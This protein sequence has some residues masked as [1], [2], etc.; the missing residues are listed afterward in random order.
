ML[1]STRQTQTPT[2]DGGVQ[3]NS[4]LDQVKQ[5]IDG[6]NNRW[7]EIS[8]VSDVIRQIARNTNLVALNA[9]IEA[10]RAGELGRG[11]AVV[12]DEVRRLATQS[13]NATADIGNVVA[14]IRQESEKALSEVQRAESQSREETAEVLLVREAQQLQSQF[15]M[16]ATAL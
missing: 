6:L 16:M 11:F 2:P 14:T 5:L 3:G 12:A 1:S 10:A 4:T 15:A 8:K 9:A 7:T 13:A